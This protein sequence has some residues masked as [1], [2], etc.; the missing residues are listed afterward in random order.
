MK[1]FK[2]NP[3]N[4]IGSRRQECLLP[5]MEPIAAHVNGIYRHDVIGWIEDNLKGRYW[6]GSLTKIVD[7]RIA[8]Y[9]AVA[10]EDPYESTIFLLSC[11]HLAKIK[12]AYS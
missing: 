9:D 6:I 10:F 11:P 2:V 4:V 12:S 5:H 8:A 7:N 1:E 3:L